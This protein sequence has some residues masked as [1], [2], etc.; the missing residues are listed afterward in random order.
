MRRVIKIQIICKRDNRFNAIDM[1]T[2]SSGK[3]IKRVTREVTGIPFLG[4]QLTLK[5]E[6]LH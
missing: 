4:C 3:I 6:S 2:K 1:V 5:P